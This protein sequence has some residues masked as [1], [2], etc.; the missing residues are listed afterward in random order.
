MTEL[1]AV[2]ERYVP[3][4]ATDK[5]LNK[6][7]LNFGLFKRGLYERSDSSPSS[8]SRFEIGCVVSRSNF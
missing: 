6:A 3:V 8:V 7:F 5:L 1:Y 4:S 2:F